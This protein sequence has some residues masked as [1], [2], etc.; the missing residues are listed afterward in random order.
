MLLEQGKRLL[1]A[2]NYAQNLMP[3]VVEDD[4]AWIN[5]WGAV[6]EHGIDFFIPVETSP[7]FY[8]IMSGPKFSPRLYRGKNE[9]RHQWTP[10]FRRLQR[11]IDICTGLPRLLLPSNC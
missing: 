5:Q 6:S 4:E 8:R 11:N 2:I 7:S 3:I 10:S 1:S 9:Y